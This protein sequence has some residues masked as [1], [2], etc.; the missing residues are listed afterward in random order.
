M[1]TYSPRIRHALNFALKHH[2][3]QTRKFRKAPYI[4][5]PMQVALILARYD[6][7]DDEL[8]G[9]ILHDVV[10]DCVETN[11]EASAMERKIRDKF[12]ADVAAIVQ[13]VTEPKRDATDQKLD[14][15]ERRTAY[16]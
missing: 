15:P 9:A 3:G 1:V 13:G 12:G 11:A 2:Q 8:I 16:L 7:P 10:E 6:R 4:S 14:T 5:H